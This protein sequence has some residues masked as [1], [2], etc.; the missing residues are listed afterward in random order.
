MVRPTLTKGIAPTLA[1]SDHQG[2]TFTKNTYAGPWRFLAFGQGNTV[3][4]A[5]WHDG[6]EDTTGS[7][8]FFN[9]QDAGS[10]YTS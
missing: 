7:N 6:F 8:D 1:I 9:A 10:T 3:G 4:W 2:N 5:R